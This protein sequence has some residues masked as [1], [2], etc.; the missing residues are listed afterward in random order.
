MCYGMVLSSVISLFLNTYYTRI[1]VKLGLWLQLK[2][3]LPMFVNSIIAG[4]IAYLIVLEVKEDIIS[5]IAACC[6][7]T[8]YYLCSSHFLKSPELD[9]IISIIKNKQV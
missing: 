7:A 1:F 4:G 3:I 5:L 2:D 8:V 9:E 6:G